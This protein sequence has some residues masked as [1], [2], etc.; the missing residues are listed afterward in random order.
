[1]PVYPEKVFDVT[2]FGEA[3]HG[4]CCCSES[5]APCRRFVLF[6]QTP[7][8]RFLG[9]KHHVFPPP[10]PFQHTPQKQKPGG[11]MLSSFAAV[12]F[13]GERSLSK[14]GFIPHIH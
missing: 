8:R 13:E 5:D 1:M 9:G 11:F 4:I 2:N 3:I 7:K 10:F 14:Q 6:F 12:V